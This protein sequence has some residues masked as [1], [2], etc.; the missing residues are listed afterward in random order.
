[1][2][3]Q[4]IK[5]VYG[6][7]VDVT[8]C[9]DEED[10][11]DTEKIKNKYG[12]IKDGLN[13]CPKIISTLRTSTKYDNKL[14]RLSN[15]CGGVAVGTRKGN[16][17]GIIREDFDYSIPEFEHY[18][19]KNGYH[20]YELTHNFCCCS[21]SRAKYMIIGVTY[22]EVDRSL[23]LDNRFDDVCDDVFNKPTKI[24]DISDEFFQHDSRNFKSVDADCKYGKYEA[25]IH[26]SPNVRKQELLNPPE[27]VV[28][29]VD[30][31]AS[32]YLHPDF[33][34]A[35]CYLMLDDCVSC[36]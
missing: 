33:V 30:N 22:N 21:D 35:N 14:I 10:C 1:M 15:W 17:R 19:D 13:C 34:S 24:N 11:I 7:C 8:D 27:S 5:A 26:S 31:F 28:K 18:R 12:D 4:T 2:V 3:W 6:Y 29:Y 20:H 23:F 16:E 36:T 32:I 25:E 9:L